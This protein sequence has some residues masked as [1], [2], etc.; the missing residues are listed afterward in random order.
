[1][2]NNQMF[3]II[4]CYYYQY[5]RELGNDSPI[6]LKGTR[7]PESQWMEGSVGATVQVNAEKLG[8]QGTSEWR[9]PWEPVLNE[10]KGSAENS[11]LCVKCQTMEISNQ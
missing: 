8:N 5:P 10:L 2:L 1:M 9:G 6:E 3:L 11:T 7:E 4:E